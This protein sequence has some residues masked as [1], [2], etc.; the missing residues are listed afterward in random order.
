VMLEM[1][2]KMVDLG[3][4]ANGEYP[5]DYV[6]RRSAMEVT[7]PSFPRLFVLHARA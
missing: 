5:E 6:Q 4:A 1:F 3:A 2:D 7:V